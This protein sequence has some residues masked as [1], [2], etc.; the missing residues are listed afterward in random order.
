MIFASVTFFSK[1]LIVCAKLLTED[2]LSYNLHNL[3]NP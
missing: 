3:I 1:L 2:I